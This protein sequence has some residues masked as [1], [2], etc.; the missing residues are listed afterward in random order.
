MNTP[1]SNHPSTPDH[2]ERT[3]TRIPRIL[4]VGAALGIAC[5]ALVGAAG[6]AVAAAPAPHDDA[7]EKAS[8]SAPSRGHGQ[9][10]HRGHGGYG[11]YDDDGDDCDGLI[12]LICHG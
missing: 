11:G 5:A 10:E 2:A 7:R 3:S 4:A 6:S 12:V 1:L 8:S 9:E